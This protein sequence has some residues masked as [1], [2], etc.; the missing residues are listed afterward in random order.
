MGDVFTAHRVMLQGIPF[1][2]LS[3]VLKSSDWPHE[4]APVSSPFKRKPTAR[5]G[6]FTAVS[7]LMPASPQASPSQ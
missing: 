5:K 6:S 4:S 7:T 2:T 1:N 3:C